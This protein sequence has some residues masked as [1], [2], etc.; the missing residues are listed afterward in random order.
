M[1]MYN[2]HM[3]RH[4]CDYVYPIDLIKVGYFD[5]DCWIGFL[6]ENISGEVII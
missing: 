4:F 5:P 3:K 2:L 6:G 1:I